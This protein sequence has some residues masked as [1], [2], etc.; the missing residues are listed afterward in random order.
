MS[1]TT[2][3]AIKFLNEHFVKC[4]NGEYI[5]TKQE[6]AELDR[7]EARAL[8]NDRATQEDLA[9]QRAKENF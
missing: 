6:W 8:M 4:E 2:E 3:E 9:W 1:Y 5:A 7:I